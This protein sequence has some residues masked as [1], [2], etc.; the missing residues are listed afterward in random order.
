VLPAIDEGIVPAIPGELAMSGA[1]GGIRWLGLE[2]GQ[3][4]RKWRSSS[5]NCCSR[6]G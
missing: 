1:C 6:V 3:V 5:G 2:D 4:R